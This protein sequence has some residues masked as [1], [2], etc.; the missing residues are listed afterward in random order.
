[1]HS[2]K[3]EYSSLNINWHIMSETYT[4]S[5]RRVKTSDVM[6]WV[7]RRIILGLFWQNL[8]SHPRE[9]IYCFLTFAFHFAVLHCL[10]V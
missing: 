2:N 1:M 8:P 10:F 9:R 6:A 5:G 7:A 4:T 3:E